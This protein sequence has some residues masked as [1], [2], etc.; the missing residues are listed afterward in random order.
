M[1]CCTPSL[2]SFSISANS[3]SVT[4]F[5]SKFLKKIT[6][7]TRLYIETKVNKFSRGIASCEGTGLIEKQIAC[8]AEFNLI[9]KFGTP[10][11]NNSD[12][13]LVIPEGSYKINVAQNFYEIVVL[14][15]PLKRVHPGIIDGTLKSEILSK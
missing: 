9:V 11:E 2:L 8:K 1:K 5:R 14:S 6:P 12:E 15:L 3:P 4:A 7:N 13:I 10:S